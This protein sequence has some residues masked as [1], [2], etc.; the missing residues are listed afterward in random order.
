[1]L[2][3][4]Q[5]GDISIKYALIIIPICVLASACEN[6]AHKSVR[7]ALIDPES[8]NFRD[9]KVCTGNKSITTGEVNA[10]NRMGAYGGFKPFFVQYDIVYF[11]DDP[12]FSRLIEHCYGTVGSDASTNESSEKG[13]W[14][15]STD[16]NPLDDSKIITIGLDATGY[17][18]KYANPVRLYIRCK[19]N[20]TE[21]YVAWDDYLGDD[22][23][24]VY[25]DWKYVTVR[26]GASKA[27][28]QR[29]TVSTDG[30]ATFM[31][32][33][34]IETLRKIAKSE[35]LVLQTTPYNES[36][37]TAIFDVKGMGDAILPLADECGWEL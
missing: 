22:S 18:E 27:N 33:S 6:Q 9:V 16:I 15:T 8:A 2:I 36:P 13:E 26:I 5:E 20:K 21:L 35:R 10:K 31:P 4:H 12:N 7:E 19:S 11:A 14:I 28:K 25:E 17:V 34:P 32:S 3:R 24:S 29:W 23:N 30:K 37:V 1:M